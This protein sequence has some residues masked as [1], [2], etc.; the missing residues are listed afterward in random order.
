MTNI[1]FAPDP[2]IHQGQLAENEENPESTINFDDHILICLNDI[3][4][5]IDID[6]N[7]DD[8]ILICL[9]DRVDIVTTTM[10]ITLEYG[11]GKKQPPHMQ[12]PCNICHCII[13]DH[14]NVEFAKVWS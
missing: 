12:V 6:I 8:H 11:K 4:I 1:F 13:V 5:A 7:F 2:P 14:I 3:D 9:D 10:K